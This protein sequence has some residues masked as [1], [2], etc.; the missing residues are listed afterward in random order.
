MVDRPGVVTNPSA[1][2]ARRS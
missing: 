1:N 2:R